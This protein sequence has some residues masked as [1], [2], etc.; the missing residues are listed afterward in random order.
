MT[1]DELRELLGID[2]PKLTAWVKLGLPHDRDGRAY[3]FDEEK[4]REWLLAEGLALEENRVGTII[5]VAN[6]FDVSERAVQYWRSKGM[7]GD[8]GRFDLD[9]IDAWRQERGLVSKQEPS[10]VRA[11][12]LEIEAQTKE[13]RYQQMAGEV[14]ELDPISRVTVRH[15]HEAKAVLER[16]PDEVLAVLPAKTP[17]R[18]RRAVRVE[19]FDLIDAACQ[20]LADTVREPE[21]LGKLRTTDADRLALIAAAVGGL[22]TTE[23][24]SLLDRARK[25]AKQ[26][27]PA[28]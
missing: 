26:T 25:Q 6:H 28:A 5:E 12:L 7:P 13:L 15:I 11:R 17:A 4:V 16:I 14:V 21:F 18:V 3:V 20:M 9:E 10:G 2:R 8:L 1:S 24:L 27:E 19:V 23:R 22:N